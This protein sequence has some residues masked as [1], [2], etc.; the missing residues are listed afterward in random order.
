VLPLAIPMVTVIVGSKIAFDDPI[1]DS[2]AKNTLSTICTLGIT[3]EDT[4]A[5]FMVNKDLCKGEPKWANY[6]KVS[7]CI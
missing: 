6:M 3:G 1:G 5:Q 2:T 4:V 7:A